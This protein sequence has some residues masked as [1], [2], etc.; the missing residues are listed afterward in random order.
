VVHEALTVTVTT[1]VVTITVDLGAAIHTTAV[2]L[3]TG[4]APR[5]A[6]TATTLPEVT[7]GPLHAV[8]VAA[9]AVTAHLEMIMKGA[10]DN[11]KE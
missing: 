1:A 3:A 5:V 7:G 11:L 2:P 8:V 6:G 9:T 4:A 10:T